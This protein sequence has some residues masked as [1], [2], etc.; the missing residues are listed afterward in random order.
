[1][2]DILQ[3]HATNRKKGKNISLRCHAEN[4]LC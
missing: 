3:S 4:R 1:M 2:T